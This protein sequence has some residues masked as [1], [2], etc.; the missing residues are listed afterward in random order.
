MSEKSIL[1]PGAFQRTL[2]RLSYEILEKNP[3]HDELVL[4]GIQRRGVFLARRIHEF[5]R[6]AEGVEVP[7]GVIDITLYRDDLTPASPAPVVHETDIPFDVSDKTLVLVDDVLFTGRTVRCALSEIMD[8]GRPRRIELCVLIDRGHRELPIRADF[9]GKNI[10]T[11][12]DEIVDVM[13][14]E[15]DGKDEVVVRRQHVG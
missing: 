4:I 2:A 6:Q 9:V 1:T 12:R 7:L 15:L 14:K 11:S 13:L 3:D 10:P 8:F 5:M